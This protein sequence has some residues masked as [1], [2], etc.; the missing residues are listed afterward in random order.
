MRWLAMQNKEAKSR[1]D[2]ATST[3]VTIMNKELSG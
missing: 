2:L 1:G 3:P